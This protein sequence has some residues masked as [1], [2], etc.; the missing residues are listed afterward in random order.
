MLSC[1]QGILV[2]FILD[3]QGAV[4][5]AMNQLSNPR[6]RSVQKPHFIKTDIV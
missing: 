4:L 3:T 2:M 5:L 6:G 1:L